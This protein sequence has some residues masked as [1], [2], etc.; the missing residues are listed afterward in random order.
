MP[1]PKTPAVPQWTCSMRVC[2]LVW[3][4]LILRRHCLTFTDKRKKDI[5]D[6]MGHGVV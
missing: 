2:V 6:N 5:Q 4:G 3:Q 1:W